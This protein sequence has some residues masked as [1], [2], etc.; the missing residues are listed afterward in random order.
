MAGVQVVVSS[1][2]VSTRCSTVEECCGAMPGRQHLCEPCVGL[3]NCSLAARGEGI[4]AGS[5]PPCGGLPNQTGKAS[6]IAVRPI[7]SG[8]CVRSIESVIPPLLSVSGEPCTRNMVHCFLPP[9]SSLVSLPLLSSATCCT[10]PSVSHVSPCWSKCGKQSET[11]TA[12]VHD[13]VAPVSMRLQKWID[14]ASSKFSCSAVEVFEYLSSPHISNTGIQGGGSGGNRPQTPF[15]PSTQQ[16]SDPEPSI[17]SPAFSTFFT[18][19]F[20]YCCFYRLPCFARL[21]TPEE[22]LETV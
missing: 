8:E 5:D 6:S 2:H 19:R 17:S 10:L 3:A 11:C 22:V 12:L 21:S 15:S 7:P 16:A 20:F 14:C 13:L 18:C 1:L 9:L 4:Y